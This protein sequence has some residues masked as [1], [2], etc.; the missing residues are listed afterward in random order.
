M[1]HRLLN[2]SRPLKT[3]T[4]PPKNEFS[5]GFSIDPS[6]PTNQEEGTPL[7]SSHSIQNSETI[8]P[9]PI[10][11]DS[12]FETPDLSL[13]ST[14]FNKKTI[15]KSKTFRGLNSPL[16]TPHYLQKQIIS[17]PEIKNPS[18]S[19]KISISKESV[20][21]EEV[22]SFSPLKAPSS[23]TNL[24]VQSMRRSIGKELLKSAA[25]CQMISIQEAQSMGGKLSLPDSGLLIPF[26][27]QL[28]HRNQETVQKNL[29]QKCSKL[30][31]PFDYFRSLIGNQSVQKYHLHLI[32][33]KII[34]I[35]FRGNSLTVL[36]E[37]PHLIALA[38]LILKENQCAVPWIHVIPASLNDL[39]S[40]V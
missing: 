40:C 15:T 32:Q 39:E 3:Q 19:S 26:L 29:L 4:R 38:E 5:L 8:S 31:V 25:S 9:Q 10:P 16:K 2:R 22:R 36:A 1:I 17:S 21:K 6:P 13:S 34:P 12:G 24:V 37:H 11:Y 33:F 35:F 28:L 30:I 14:V 20:Q 7:P 18:F 23:Q 27:S